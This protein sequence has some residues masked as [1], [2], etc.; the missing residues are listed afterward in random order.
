MEY[1]IVQED[2]ETGTYFI[3]FAPDVLERS[4]LKLGDGLLWEILTDDDGKPYARIT[5]AES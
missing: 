2:P 3:V 1:S 5:K 4:G